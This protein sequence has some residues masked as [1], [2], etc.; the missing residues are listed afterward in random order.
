MLKYD[1]FKFHSFIEKNKFDFAWQKKGKRFQAVFFR[2]FAFSN[3]FKVLND[4]KSFL[5]QQISK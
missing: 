1:F 2:F 4:E 3:H 5:P